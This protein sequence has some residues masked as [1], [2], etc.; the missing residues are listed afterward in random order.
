MIPESRKA[1]AEVEISI[2]ECTGRFLYVYEYI[3]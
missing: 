2:S 1:T 3:K